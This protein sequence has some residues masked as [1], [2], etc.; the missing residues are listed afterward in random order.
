MAAAARPRIL[1][2]AGVNGAGKSSVGGTALRSA[3]LA[4]FNPDAYT[5]EL[6]TRLGLPPREANAQAWEEGRRRLEQAI[7]RGTP[8]AFETTLGGR[9]IVDMLERA[10][11]THDVHIWYCGLASLELHLRRV[12]ERVAAG[13][14]DIDPARIAERHVASPLHLVRLMPR[15]ASLALYDNS[16]SVAAGESVPDPMLVLR[17]VGRRVLHPRDLAALEATPGWARPL[18]ERALQLHEAAGG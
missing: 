7:A 16:V 9:T 2:L 17:C 3:G 10:A 15:L 1:V 14:H 5:R 13:G 6:E 8:H 11:H 18:V 4:W 12:R